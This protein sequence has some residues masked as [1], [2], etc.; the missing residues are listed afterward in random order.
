M[1]TPNIGYKPSMNQHGATRRTIKTYIGTKLNQRRYCI[2]QKVKFCFWRKNTIYTDS[3]QIEES[4]GSRLTPSFIVVPASGS[5][6]IIQLTQNILNIL[7]SARVPLTYGRVCR[8]AFLVCNYQNQPLKYLLIMLSY[9]VMH[10]GWLMMKRCLI[11][12]P[13]LTKNCTKVVSTRNPNRRGMT[14]QL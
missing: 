9:S 8:V 6:D 13:L 12:G 7:K 11:T 4:F 10:I 3:G 14:S 2:K 1:D 5:Q